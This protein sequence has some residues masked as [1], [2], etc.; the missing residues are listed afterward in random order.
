M[1]SNRSLDVEGKKVH[2]PTSNGFR[3]LTIRET[4]FYTGFL[5]RCDGRVII[6][7]SLKLICS[8]EQRLHGA[9]V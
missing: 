3:D 2:K 6:A 1:I 5:T 9:I 7:S 8:L 4:I